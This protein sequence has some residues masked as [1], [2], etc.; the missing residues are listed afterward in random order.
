MTLSEFFSGW[1]ERYALQVRESSFERKMQVVQHLA[2]FMGLFLDQIRADE[3]EDA[4]AGVANRS[5]RQAQL[6][7]AALK[8]VLRSAQERGHVVDGG[9]LRVKRPRVE[10]REPRFL[11]WAEVDELAAACTEGRLI[12]VACLTGLRQGELF[13]LRDSDLDFDAG[14]VLVTRAARAV[15]PSIERRLGKACAARTYL[16]SRD[17]HCGSSC[18][19]GSRLRGDWSSRVRR[20]ESGSG[21]TSWLG[22]FGRRYDAS[23]STG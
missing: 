19:H 6:A 18:W 23:G 2:P 16:R 10:E 4:I 15:V 1:C 3:V 14:A 21:T 17:R 22:C 8:Q 7:L 5:P 13:A 11:S 9:V 20:V 12:V